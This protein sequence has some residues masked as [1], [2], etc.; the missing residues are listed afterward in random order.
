MKTKCFV[1][2]LVG[3]LLLLS[4]DAYS[5]KKDRKE[6]KAERAEA[7][8]AAPDDQK[9]AAP[10]WR[11]T[12]DY[13][14]IA[15]TWYEWE[16][17]KVTITQDGE[18]FRADGT[19]TGEDNRENH[20][21]V[22]GVI[23]KDG[24][25]TSKLVYDKPES[26]TKD[27]VVKLDPDGKVIRGRTDGDFTW[28]LKEPGEAGFEK[29]AHTKRRKKD[30]ESRS[31]DGGG[32]PDVAAEDK[33]TPQTEEPSSD[34][35]KT[36]IVEAKGSGKDRDE[37]L[38]DAFRDAVRKVV[39]AY[40]EQETVVKNDQI[41]KDQV[42]TYSGGCVKTHGIVSEDSG[43]GLI[44]VTIWALVE[45]D[46]VVKR[47]KAASV[48][49]KDFPG[50]D[51]L[52]RLV[53]RRAKEKAAEAM[54]RSVLEGFPVN[55]VK[56]VTEGEP[57]EIGH[58]DRGATIQVQIRCEV[59]AAA[60]ASFRQRL[61]SVL[62][63]IAEREDEG[64]WKLT[65]MRDKGS[66]YL[67]ERG[68][69]VTKGKVVVIVSTFTTELWDRMAWKM[70]VIDTCETFRV[71]EE[72]VCQPITCRL[73]LLGK[74]GEL[75]YPDGFAPQGVPLVYVDRWPPN[76]EGEPYK[77]PT[78]GIVSILGSYGVHETYITPSMTVV[79]NITLTDNQLK[80]LREGKIECKLEVS[81]GSRRDAVR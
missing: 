71:F 63:A 6:K 23:S 49:V 46:K 41:I 25:I 18:K 35:P 14:L 65:R 61:Q 45:Q 9:S 75:I 4:S 74:N 2:C 27:F 56:A 29:V 69:F 81:T 55:C 51:I 30:K 39:G 11:M 8:Q 10:S 43:G 32:K 68:R 62:H 79:R 64:F 54:L 22:E 44:Q 31:S 21:F 28:T 72:A 40:V 58:D 15:G 26:L 60:F 67:I 47:L 34:Q 19:F 78:Q 52:D 1:T 59:D 48:S 5:A 50:S 42:L 70:Y 33:P 73:S 24:R 66:S 16:G 38:K 53:S 13:P 17:C 7:R 20:F 57:K 3:L 36:M 12:G 77:V 76:Y 80:A 37:A